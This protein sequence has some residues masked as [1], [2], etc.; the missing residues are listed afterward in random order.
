MTKEEEIRAN[1]AVATIQNSWEMMANRAIELG[2]AVEMQKLEI[3]K[4]QAEIAELKDKP[5]EPPTEPP[6]G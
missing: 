5:A 4:L 6:V 2:C 3:A 1:V